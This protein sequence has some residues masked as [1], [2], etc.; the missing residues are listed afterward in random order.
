[1]RPPPLPYAPVVLLTLLLACGPSDP[2]GGDCERY[3]FPLSAEPGT[4]QHTTCGSTAC[5]DGQS[6][7]TSGPHCGLTLAC[8]AHDSVQ[9]AC[10]WLHNL[11]HGHAVFLYNCPEGCPEVVAALE[12]ARQEAR[13]G[14]NGVRRAL[15]APDPTLP[16][17]VAALLWRRAWLA[18]T[19]D[20]QAL[21]CFLQHQDADA[22]EP[23]LT[24]MP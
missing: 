16:N 17:R 19:A 3:S 15:V 20:P 4:A 13:A 21:R 7:P 23:G 6:P 22:P 2:S 11:E 1:M 18:D 14:T 5:G 24:C 12:A 8:R 10:K 9:D